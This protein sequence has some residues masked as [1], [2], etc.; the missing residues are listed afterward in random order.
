M[1]QGGGACHR[2][3]GHYASLNINKAIC[4]FPQAACE[5]ALPLKKRLLLGSAI[6]DPQ[7]LFLFASI[8]VHSR[9]EKSFFK[10]QRREAASPYRSGPLR[11][12]V[13]AK[14]KAASSIDHQL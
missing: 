2:K 11:R 14:G 6:R 3:L 4:E 9:F 10:S 1:C 12:T 8:R 5:R 7:S 13:P